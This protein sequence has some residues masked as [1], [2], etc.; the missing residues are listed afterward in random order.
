VA[1]FTILS[2]NVET[3]GETKLAAI[4]QY[5]AK[6]IQAANADLVLFIESTRY[7]Q[8]DIV[9]DIPAALELV[10]G[11]SWWAF[12]SEPTGKAWPMPPAIPYSTWP[13]AAEL[14]C[15][16]ADL[17]LC[18]DDHPAARTMTLKATYTSQ[19]EST[20]RVAIDR[21]G[22][23]KRDLETYTTMFRYDPAVYNDGHGPLLALG[24]YVGIPL[25]RSGQLVSYDVA[26]QDIGYQTPGSGFTGRVPYLLNLYFSSTSTLGNIAATFPLACFHAPFG[27]SLNPRVAANVG[28]MRLASYTL[29]N[30]LA[31]LG[32]QPQSAVAADFNVDFDWTES[33]GGLTNPIP[34]SRSVSTRNYGAFALAGFALGIHEKTTL[35]TVN[36]AS[37]TWTSPLQFRSNAYDN[38]L[39]RG[40]GPNNPISGGVAGAIDLVAD[41]YNHAS[42]YLSTLPIP[43]PLSMYDAFRIVREKISDHLPIACQLTVADRP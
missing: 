32:A 2:W 20:C 36:A 26:A 5:V 17:G 6:V 14:A 30:A 24:S 27:N 4:A 22:Y 31:P 40:V 28:M 38:I 7:A 34:D 3:F 18:Y 13:K 39:V 41:T 25:L 9:R 37:P 35:T 16:K 42:N 43:S 12:G 15:Y 29:T 19:D 11:Q 21:A 33:Y 8:S 23:I 1:H 10:T